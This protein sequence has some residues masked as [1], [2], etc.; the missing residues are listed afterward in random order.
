MDTFESLLAALAR[1]RV[2][3]I[4]VGGLA[5]AVAGYPRVTEDV[6]L[7][8]EASEANLH[9]LLGQLRRFGTGA[10]AELTPADF[11]M[12]EGAVRVAEDFDV[13]LFTLM[14]GRTYHDLL[15]QT[16]TLVVEDVAVR[17]LNAAGL[18]ALKSGSVRPKD[19]MDVL[20]LREILR[21]QAGSG[22]QE[23]EGRK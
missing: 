22:E 4:V 20:M 9:R 17:F 12:E 15:P 19:Q 8:V 6:D 23:D 11:P 10:A 1:A 7:L 18:I 16:H 3:F 14:G 21:Q 5:V 2:D 13:D